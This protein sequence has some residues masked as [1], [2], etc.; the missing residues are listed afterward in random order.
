MATVSVTGT[1]TVTVTIQQA[2]AFRP[3]LGLMLKAKVR[4]SVGNIVLNKQPARVRVNARVRV[5]A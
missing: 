5:R 1:D 3:K 2:W 4:S